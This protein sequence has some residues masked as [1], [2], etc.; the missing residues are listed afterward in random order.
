MASIGGFPESPF[1][2]P[3]KP[4][5][6]S[7]TDGSDQR[8]AMCSPDSNSSPAMRASNSPG[9]GIPVNGGSTGET[10][11]VSVKSADS[12]FASGSS[13]TDSSSSFPLFGGGDLSQTFS[14]FNQVDGSYNQASMGQPQNTQSQPTNNIS[15]MA[16]DL[17]KI[18]PSIASH[19]PGKLNVL[20]C[21]G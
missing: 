4:P 7:L 5:H 20:A 1:T 11:Q 2:R 18:D 12:P 13:S 16:T 14:D 3:A 15:D 8:S 21:F 6:D 19:W 9:G 17:S 10:P